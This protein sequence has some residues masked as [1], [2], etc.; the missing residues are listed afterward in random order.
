MTNF[1]FQ[2]SIQ[3]RPAKQ[4]GLV[5]III[6]R[7]RALD[8][9]LPWQTDIEKKPHPVHELCFCECNELSCRL[10]CPVIQGASNKTGYPTHG[11][12]WSYRWL[13]RQMWN[14]KHRIHSLFATLMSN[15]SKTSSAQIMAIHGD[16]LLGLIRNW[17]LHRSYNARNIF[18]R[19]SRDREVEIRLDR[20]KLVLLL[21]PRLTS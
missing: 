9:Q 14:M 5:T 13:E 19:V 17:Y 11:L 12:R 2:K 3:L 4:L 8:P 18:G 21:Y 15:I 16:N 1:F 7:N 6:H 20:L 10:L